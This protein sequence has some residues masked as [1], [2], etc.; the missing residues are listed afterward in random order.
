MHE[1]RQMVCL[2][3]PNDQVTMNPAEMRKL[4]TE[5]YANIFLK[6]TCDEAV[7]AELLQL[8]SEDQA[9]FNTDLTLRELTMAVAQMASG[10]SLG[11]NDLP[12]DFFFN[13]YGTYWGQTFC[14]D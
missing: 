5:F 12:G 4:A 9:I 6:D 2:G 8:T 13:I 7:A 10:R 3:L 1:K 14:T 11:K